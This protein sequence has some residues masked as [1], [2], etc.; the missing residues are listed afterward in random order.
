MRSATGVDDGALA[1]GEGLI[2]VKP[3]RVSLRL[4]RGAGRMWRAGLL[5]EKPRHCEKTPAMR[6]VTS[7]A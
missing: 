4:T 1:G 6:R 7:A 3:A 2:K 5:S